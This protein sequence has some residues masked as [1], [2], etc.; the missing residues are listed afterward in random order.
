VEV[1]CYKAHAGGYGAKSRIRIPTTGVEE[2][3]ASLLKAF[4]EV[5]FWD[6]LIGLLLMH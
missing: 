6:S 5:T 1:S 4:I 3:K 2:R